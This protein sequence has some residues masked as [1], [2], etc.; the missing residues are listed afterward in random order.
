MDYMKYVIVAMYFVFLSSIGLLF[1]RLNTNQSDFFRSGCR[2]NWWLVGMS[3]FMSGIST[4]TFIANAGVAY[5]AGSSILMIYLVNSICYVILALGVAAWYRQ[6]RVTTF[7]EIVRERFGGGFQQFFT[8]YSMVLMIIYGGFGLYML[9]LFTHT[10]FDFPIVGVI[11]ALGCIVLFYTFTGGNWAVLVGA[12]LQSLVLL[13]MI[14]LLAYLALKDI[15]GISGFFETIRSSE[16]FSRDFAV[17]K[18]TGPGGLYNWRWLV[19][20]MIMQVYGCLGMS[21]G[22]RFFSCKDGREARRAVTFTLIVSTAC[23]LVYFIPPMVARMLYDAELAATGIANPQDISY[24][25]MSKKLLPYGFLPLMIVAMFAAQMSTLDSALNANAAVFVMNGYPS[26]MRLAGKKP[27]E[28]PKFLLLLGRI[29]TFIFGALVVAIGIFIARNVGSQGIFELTFKVNGVIGVPVLLPL[30]LGFFIKRSP[31]WSGW[32]CMIASLI[33]SIYGFSQG[34]ATYNIAMASSAT[35]IVVF[36]LTCFFWKKS[37]LD[38]R[39][40]IEDLFI[41]MRKPIDFEQEIGSAD[42]LLVL[43]MIGILATALGSMIWLFM[44]FPNEP[45]QRMY[46]AIVAVSVQS[47]GLLLLGIFMYKK[48]KMSA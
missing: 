17:I 6:A 14:F 12:F 3:F 34:V 21:G 36:V 13:P 18:D 1:K 22:H 42:E 5:K 43:K 7:A 38:S 45:I 48:K 8:Y 33:P 37:N 28:D 46:I 31:W 32:A 35:G 27:S 23:A 39:T 9:A 24:A 2:G 29:F 26:L 44:L 40:A 16:E 4:Q 19:G 10:A 30:F 11:G 41:R 47:V 15:G 25:F 20:V